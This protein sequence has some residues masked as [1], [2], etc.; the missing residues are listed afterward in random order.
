MEALF[1][2]SP[3][4]TDLQLGPPRNHE[5]CIA[6]YVTPINLSVLDPRGKCRA[7]SV[8]FYV[9]GV[10]TCTAYNNVSN[11]Y[12]YIY[13]YQLSVHVKTKTKYS[14]QVFSC[15]GLILVDFDNSYVIVF[16]FVHDA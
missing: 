15:W 5:H 11:L 13:I 2:F 6:G 10:I 3:K 12:I 16:T 14:S 1:W 9:A 4:S 7:E 8:L